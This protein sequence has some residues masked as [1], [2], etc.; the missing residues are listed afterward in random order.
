MIVAPFTREHLR[1]MVIQQKQQGLEHLLTSEVCASLENGSSYAALDGDEVLACAGIIEV[2]P[3]RAVAWAYL[4]QNVGARMRGVTRA[5]KRFLDIS[6]YRRIEMDVDCNF[7]QAHRWAK[8][9]G[10]EME[11]ERRR[12]FTPDGRDCALY[13]MVRT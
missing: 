4:S 11:C 2:S 13:A 9:L 6:T 12:S 7:P 10:F 5:V 1:V 3:G 8:M